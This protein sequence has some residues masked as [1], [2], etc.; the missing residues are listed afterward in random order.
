MTKTPLYHDETHKLLGFTEKDSTSWR[1]LTIFSYPI[2]RTTTQKD[3]EKILREKGATFIKGV[4]NYYDTADQDWF[5]CVISEAQERKVVINRT[6]S[7][8]YQDPG[9]FKRVIIE[10]PDENSLVKSH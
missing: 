5:P 9:S 7:L 2:A 1:A 8:G 6:N 3:A 4:W 10:N